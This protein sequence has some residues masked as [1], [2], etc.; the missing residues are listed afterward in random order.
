MLV[1]AARRELG[2]GARQQSG[3]NNCGEGGFLPPSLRGC[4][5]NTATVPCAMHW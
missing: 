2:G 4:V 3:F 5:S 1:L